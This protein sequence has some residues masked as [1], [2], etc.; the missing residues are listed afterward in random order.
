[1]FNISSFLD[2]FSKNLKDNSYIRGL[3]IDVVKKN[4]N[5]TLKEE[6]L[7]IKEGIVYFKG[8]PALKNKIFI[9]K[10]SILEEINKTQKFVDIK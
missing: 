1:M 2:K 6:D 9:N 8:S 3:I 10:E 7:E 4:T 5:I